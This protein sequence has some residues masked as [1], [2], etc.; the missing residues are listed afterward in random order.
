[1]QLLIVDTFVHK[2]VNMNFEYLS[3]NKEL[4]PVLANWYFE[5][6][7][8][9]EKGR[10]LDTETQKLQKFLNKDQIPLILLAIENDELLGA[11][12]LKYREMSIYPDKEHWIGGVYT[13]KNHRGKGIAKQIILKLIE[14]ASN[15]NIKKLYLQTEN[16][17][18][19]LYRRLGWKPIEQ[20]NYHNIEVLVMEREI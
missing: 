12:Q 11:A 3:D 8:N 13:S 9:K 1:M 17:N 20:V 2:K 14:I 15:L 4:I 19:G 10:T 16:L 5:E 7:G 6:W 18:G